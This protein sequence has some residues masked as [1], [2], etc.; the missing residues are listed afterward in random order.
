MH[1]DDDGFLVLHSKKR[2]KVST[3]VDEDTTVV[4][5]SECSVPF[6]DMPPIPSPD[7][8]LV[9]LLQAYE[10]RQVQRDA[11]LHKKLDC[12]E[13]ALATLTSQ[14]A[15]RPHHDDTDDTEASQMASGPSAQ[16][17]IERGVR[18]GWGE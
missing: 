4:E 6:A 17:L 16:S 8:T 7:E 13:A 9:R 11:T 5:D 12:M 1:T 14:L 3:T 18:A 10:T 2:R 15:Q